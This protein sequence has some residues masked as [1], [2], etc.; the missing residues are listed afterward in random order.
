MGLILAFD[1]GGT[2]G[3]CIIRR[4]LDAKTF[5]IVEALEIKWKDRFDVFPLIT[6]YTANQIEAIVIEEFRLFNNLAL[7][8]SQINSDF[9]SVRIIGFIELTCSIMHI[10]DRI[11]FQKPGLR[12]QTSISPEHKKQ[13]HSVHVVAAYLH[14]K[15]YVLTHRSTGV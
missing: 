2:T 6:G 1:P 13:L 9:P 12:L 10:T 4:E 15:Y 5:A 14:A 3:V 7:M 11:H 8:Q